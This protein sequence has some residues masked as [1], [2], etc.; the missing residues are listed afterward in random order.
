MRAAAESIKS[1]PN[2]GI[3]GSTRLD[4]KPFA[5]INLNI[6]AE[7]TLS[8]CVLSSFIAASRFDVV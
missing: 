6:S 7:S 2:L 3:K 5:S 1:V 8:A 4:S